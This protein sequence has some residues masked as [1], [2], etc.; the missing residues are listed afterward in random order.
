MFPLQSSLLS[1]VYRGS[2]R[3]KTTLCSTLAT[4]P[5]AAKLP[6]FTYDAAGHPLGQYPT[7]GACARALK[8]T[9]ECVYS[10]LRRGSIV[11]ARYYLSHKATF[12]VA[13]FNR[14]QNPLEARTQHPRGQ[15]RHAGFLEPE[16][17]DVR[18]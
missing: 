10:G 13:D 18:Y 9:R 16:F 6:V 11:Q 4:P 15:R 3:M 8:L 17:F 5:T 14:A 7:V 12:R 2:R 1:P